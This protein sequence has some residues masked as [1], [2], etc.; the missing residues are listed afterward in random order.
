MTVPAVI[1]KGRLKRRLDPRY[2]GEIDVASKLA[3]VFGF[4]VEFLNLVSVNH[5]DAGFFRVGGIDKHF[6]RHC[7]RSHDTT[8]TA[9]GGA[10]S[11]CPCPVKASP[12][13]AALA[14]VWPPALSLLKVAR[15]IALVSDRRFRLPVQ[16]PCNLVIR[17]RRG[18][19]M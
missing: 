5:H 7:F 1:D 12:A 19:F 18:L 14:T 6:L 13:T 16:G 3:F 8:C 15:C 17:H 11:A 9:P 4:K 2:L 10:T